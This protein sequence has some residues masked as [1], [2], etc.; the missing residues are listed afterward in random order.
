MPKKTKKTGFNSEQLKAIQHKNG[1]MLVIAGAGTGKTRVITERIAHII[2]S[3]WCRNSEVL[4]LTFTEKATAELEERVDRLMPL[5]YEAIPI[6]TFHGFCDRI[7]RE[8]GVDIGLS[9]GFR[10][11]AGVEQWMFVKE[12][13]F[14]FELDYY[15]PMGNPTS[16]IDAL[17]SAFSRFKEELDSPE[18]VME[19]AKKMEDKL[20]AKRL[21]ELGKAYQKYQ[22]LLAQAG[23]LDY[24][25]LHYKVIELFRLRPNILK[26]LQ[27]RYRYI[28]VDE[29]QDT[30]IAQNAIVDQL[31]TQHKNIMVVG[32]DDQ[33]I[34]KFRGAAISNI[35]QFK[36]KYP[37]AE[38]VVLTQNYRSNQAILDLAYASVQYNN[39][40]RLEVKAGV[41]KKL[42]GQRPGVAESIQ[43]VHSARLEE[44]VD[45]VI[46]EILRLAQ[47][48]TG[49]K[50]PFSEIAILCRTNAQLLPFAAELKKRN[51]PYEFVSEKGLYLKEEI[52]DLV[53]V[54]RVLANPTDDISFYRVLRMAVWGVSMDIVA[55]LI[56][57]ARKNYQPVY[58]EV[59]KNESTKF[60]RD[61]LND[62]FEFSRSHTAG[63]TLYRFCQTIKLYEQ[64]LAAGTIEAE[65]EIMSIA[66]FFNKIREFERSAS[67]PTGRQA[68]KTVIDFV[69]YLDLAQEAGENPSARFEPVE[70]DGVFV[71][72]VHGAKGLEFEAVFLA[73]LTNDRFPN[74]N[75]K[76]A[77]AIPDELVHEILTE[78]DAHIE[79]ERRLFYVAVTRAKE[80]L[81]MLHSDFYGVSF[82]ANPRKK[83]R[84][85]FIDEVI[86]QIVF[87]QIEKTPTALS[88]QQVEPKKEEPFLLENRPR[89]TQFSYSQLTKFKT[90]PRQYQYANIY[91]IP[92]P[93]A[94][95]LSF[96]ISMHSTLQAFYKSVEQQ[97]QASLFTE[98]QPDL[99]LEHLLQIYD[100]KWVNQGYE[101]RQ[102]MELRKARGREI[103]V[104]FYGHFKEDIPRIRFLEKG[105]KLKVGDYTLS[106]R[107][108]R[109]DDLP[110]GTLEIIDY[111]TGRSKTEKEAAEDLQLFIYALA[112][113]ECFNLP[114]SRLTLY[115]LDEDI[116]VSIQ[117]DTKKLE[118]AK[119]EI[120][121][122]ADEI[123]R[124][125]FSPTPSQHKCQYCPFNKICDSSMS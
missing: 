21:L 12:H 14:E 88:T 32:D 15:R 83:K 112:A 50:I 44:E 65:E 111:K 90:C 91:K 34:Y 39:P 95:N 115:F 120:Q 52:L 92:E 94:A 47:D 67:M 30:N 58:K 106:G 45:F 82:S 38:K 26:Y 74:T 69:K 41:D 79:E 37:E 57:S 123:N 101:G 97:K 4:A 72:T 8:F 16:F 7:L 93:P 98:F 5:G 59:Q 102:H 42:K 23:F 48:D 87:T 80:H 108:D 71:S 118:A 107:L 3:G 114:A 33:S 29:Y 10:I 54:L 113:S 24:A 75:R 11:L 96:G 62:C 104:A 89:V 116:R 9:P 55:E 66:A 110:D 99:S 125:N 2:H 61:T 56:A 22:A 84:S 46:G 117:P 27:S 13:L 20:E 124:S 18:M 19:A 86:E 40:D 35:L 6:H 85:R 49:P 25:D 103:L 105:F 81:Y 31:A 63:E 53:A 70:R 36:E 43:L 60:L 109:A 17:L 121:S 73:S 119:I 51:I 78:A 68:E 28:L 77:I 122:I 64:L 1:P 100:E 76:D